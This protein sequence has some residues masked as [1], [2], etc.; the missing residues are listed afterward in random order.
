MRVR[1]RRN[2][3]RGARARDGG[4]QDPLTHAITMGAGFCAEEGNA[5]IGGTA[6]C[7]GDGDGGAICPVFIRD[8]ER[9]LRE[10]GEEIW[11]CE[12]LD[13]V[14]FRVDVVFGVGT[15]DHDAAVLEE[16]G[17]GVI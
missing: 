1:G 4:E 12:D 17:F 3:A 11:R 2:R 6:L 14:F 15:G 8:V 5:Q 9:R 10:A 7:D 13:A 16:D